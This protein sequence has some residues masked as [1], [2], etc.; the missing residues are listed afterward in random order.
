LSWG[1]E[2]NCRQYFLRTCNTECGEE[3]QG[4]EK[5]EEEKREQRGKK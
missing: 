5:E 1:E 3:R 4:E 2:R